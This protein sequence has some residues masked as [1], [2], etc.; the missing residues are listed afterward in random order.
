MEAMALGLPIISTNVGGIPYLIEN[1]VT[2]YL[3]DDNDATAMIQAIEKIVTNPEKTI[4]IVHN[5][6][7]SVENM[8]WNVIKSK[9][10]QLI[11]E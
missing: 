10:L 2:A 8:D 6:R 11:N 7:N 5:A 3:V 9:W 1:N 4:Q